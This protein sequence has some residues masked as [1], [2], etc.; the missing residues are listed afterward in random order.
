M[1][2]SVASPK[3]V[4]RHLQELRR[5]VIFLSCGMDEKRPHVSEGRLRILP[6]RSGTVREGDPRRTKCVLEFEFGPEP[7]DGL[8]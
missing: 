3:R 5:G 1:C 4:A 8:W 7:L 2:E 6:D